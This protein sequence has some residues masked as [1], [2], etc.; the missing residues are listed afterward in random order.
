MIISRAAFIVSLSICL[1]I[2][3]ISTACLATLLYRIHTRHKHA[4]KAKDQ[5]LRSKLQS[6]ISRMAREIDDDFR[7]QFSGCLYIPPEN[8]YLQAGSPVEMAPC[9]RIGERPAVPPKTI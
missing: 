6:R 1:L 5:S 9:E 7:R 3:F 2:A 4:E 8:P